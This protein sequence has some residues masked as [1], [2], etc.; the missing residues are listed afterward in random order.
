MSVFSQK[1]KVWKGD[2]RTLR[3]KVLDRTNL[4]P[5]TFHWSIS[6]DESTPP[7]LV[8]TSGDGITTQGRH[9]LVEL[10]RTDTD[11]ASGIAADEYLMELQAIDAY[12]NALMSSSGILELLDPIEK[13]T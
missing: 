13:R 1:V 5:L 8:K 9:I 10:E 11:E 2:S 6:V 3:F 7:V 12:D 4:G